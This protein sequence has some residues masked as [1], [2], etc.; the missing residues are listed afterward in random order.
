MRAGGEFRWF[1]VID[2][3]CD[4]RNGGPGCHHDVFC[5]DVGCV[6]GYHNRGIGGPVYLVLLLGREL[7]VVFLVS[8]LVLCLIVMLGRRF[9]L[10]CFMVLEMGVV[11][12]LVYE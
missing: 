9:L 10:L 5:Y 11:L 6:N 1:K 8:D 2:C 3:F 12:Y 7:F 4:F